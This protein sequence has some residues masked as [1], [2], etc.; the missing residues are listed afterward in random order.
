MDNKTIENIAKQISES[1]PSGVKELAGNVEQR[2]K[3]TLQ[4][5]L[6]KLDLVT[7]EEMD[8]QQQ[9]LLRLRERV[10]QLEQQLAEQ[11]KQDD[12]QE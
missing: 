1:M 2:V 4:S 12:T 7:R 3:Q 10:E 6:S 9:L 11:N 8:V 5:Q